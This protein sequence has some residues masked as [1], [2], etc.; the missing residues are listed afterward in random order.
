MA[1]KTDTK[2][3]ADDAKVDEPD[4]GDTPELIDF[5]EE[6]A[7]LESR[8]LVADQ[9]R[10]LVLADG[11]VQLIGPGRYPEDAPDEWAEPVA[12]HGPVATP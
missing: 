1:A 3:D 11:S 6:G 7:E 5:D 12:L 8:T 4:D 2:K 9:W 10:Q